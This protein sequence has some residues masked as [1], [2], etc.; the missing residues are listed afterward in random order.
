M[1]IWGDCAGR[2]VGS[3]LHLPEDRSSNKFPC[4]QPKQDNDSIWSYTFFQSGPAASAFRVTRL[5]YEIN[6]HD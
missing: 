1:A 6:Y 4:G 5:D 2:I 3:E